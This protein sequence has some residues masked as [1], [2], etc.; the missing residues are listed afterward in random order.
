LIVESED[1]YFA[2][3]GLY[4]VDV[5]RSVSDA[6]P[7]VTLSTG[8]GVDVAES[9]TVTLVFDGATTVNWPIGTV[10]LD[11]VRVDLDPDAHL[12]FRLQVPVILPVTRRRDG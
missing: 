7:L 6:T 11:F 4:E 9:N 1:I 3:D 8:N 12:G 5:K 10:T 2:T